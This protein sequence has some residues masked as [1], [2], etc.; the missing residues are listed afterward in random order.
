MKLTANEMGLQQ[1]QPMFEAISYVAEYVEP[2][3]MNHVQRVSDYARFVAEYVLEWDSEETT[4][5][6]LAA[7]LHDVGKTT[8]PRELLLR[9]GA[10]TADERVYIRQ[11][12]HHGFNIIENVERTLVTNQIAFDETLFSYAK[13][14]ALYHHENFD[15]SGYPE[16]RTGNDIP[17]VAR[18]VK[19]VD[20]IDALM[21]VRPYKTAWPW[22]STRDELRRL[23]GSQFDPHLVDG[24]LH[25][26]EEF[27]QLL[28]S[29]HHKVSESL[30]LG[31]AR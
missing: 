24:L 1:L 5:I 4:R 21:S 12:A 23:A 7:L 26:E 6:A 2:D 13:Q 11:H 15:G 10:L 19:M 8:I 25:E 29:T 27:I 30:V 31:A 17:M 28:A 14:V 16:G 22:K 20:V 18:V 3:A 9:P